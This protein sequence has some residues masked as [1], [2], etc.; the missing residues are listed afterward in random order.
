MKHLTGLVTAIFIVMATGAPRS[1]A[2]NVNVINL[3]GGLMKAAIG[4]QARTEWR[5]INALELACIEEQL[6]QRGLSSSSLAQR[7]VFP[8]DGSM[9]NI[10]AGCVRAVTS[11]SPPPPSSMPQPLPPTTSQPLSAAPTFDCAKAKSATAHILCLDPVGAKADWDLTSAYWASLFSLPASEQDAF[12]RRHEDWPQSLDKISRLLPDQSAYSAQQRQCVLGAFHKRAEMYRAR[13]RGNSLA[14]SK[15]SP[16]EHAKIQTRLIALG[17]FD[18]EA[19]G[20][21]GPMTREAIRRF[22]MESGE[23]VSAFLAPAQQSP[24]EQLARAHG[25]DRCGPGPL[26]TSGN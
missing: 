15:L 23:S 7:G 9:A 26:N 14:K 20:E 13:L 19:D 4:E 22:Q 2:Q 18:G 10:R 6:Q 11:I 8:T 16:E 17:H 3:F 24:I 1:A 5:K 25:S 21:F 12:K